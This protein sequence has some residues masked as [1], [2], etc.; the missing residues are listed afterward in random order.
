MDSHFAG[1]CRP[2]SRAV[3]PRERF[4]YTERE[5]FSAGMSVNVELHDLPA[6]AGHN[7]HDRKSRT[8]ALRQRR[9]CRSPRCCSPISSEA[10]V[11]RLRYLISIDH[12]LRDRRL[13]DPYAELEKRVDYARGSQQGWRR[14][15]GESTHLPIGG[16]RDLEPI[17]RANGMPLNQ[18]RAVDLTKRGATVAGARSL[19]AVDRSG[20][21]RAELSRLKD[22]RLIG[23]DLTFKFRPYPTGKPTT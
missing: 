5:P 20:F 14:S 2:Q 12:V 11:G 16:L 3:V 8:T 9:R 17:A 13:V 15:Y 19:Q 22:W 23:A 1:S 6:T 18:G 10:S 21:S 4:A 7:D